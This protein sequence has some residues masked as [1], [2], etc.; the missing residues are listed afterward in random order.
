MKSKRPNIR[1]SSNA[2]LYLRV[3]TEE[4][5][6]DAFGLES[7][8]RECRRLCT[9]RGWNV[10]RVFRDAGVSAW[11]DVDRPAF[12]D[13]MA[14]IRKDRNV[15]LIFYDYSRFGR[16]TE[17]ALRAFR[18]LDGM[19]VFTIAATNSAID[20]RTAGGRTARRNELSNAEDFSDQNSEKT[21]ARMKAAF[22]EGRWCRPAPLGYEGTR[23][24][25][26]G[27]S[28]IVPLESEAELVR[29]SFELMS[30]GNDRLA[31]VLRKV[32][33]MGLRSKKGNKLT[34]HSFK[35]ML[36]NPVY[37]GMVKSNKWRETRKG[38]HQPLV[39]E[40]IF[41]NVQLVLRGKKPIAAPYQRN[42][43]EFPLRRFLRCSECGTPLTGGPSRSATGKTYDYYNCYKCH[44]VKSLSAQKAAGEFVELLMRLRPTPLLMAEFPAILKEELKK[45]TGDS[46]ATVGRLKADLSER[47]NS[48]GKLLLKYVDGDKNIAPYFEQMNR[49]FE[50]QIADIRAQIAELEMEKVTLAELMEFSKS[51]LVDIAT[52]WERADV[53]QKQRV[54][55]VLFPKGLKYDPGKGILNSD[56]DCLFNQLEVFASGKMLMVRP[57]RFELPTLWFVAKYSI[58][59]SYG[60]TTQGHPPKRILMF[61]NRWHFG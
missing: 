57:E 20:C 32:T 61:R 25:V 23:T 48:Q 15:N 36:S 40:G 6:K 46:A 44:A 12:I 19:G 52:A 45:R 39:D 2:L 7:Q 54:Q 11:S 50:E 14:A 3:S 24:K 1:I 29:K 18:E 37:I 43:A 5:A 34:Q 33:A 47:I 30:E 28:N 27:H 16:N 26:K 59:L 4:Q 10:V 42:R 56:K 49:Q 38:V 35:K 60:R 22:E 31:D 13:M 9:E 51:L 21:S 17:K 58:Q 8:E 41:R 55:N 53:D